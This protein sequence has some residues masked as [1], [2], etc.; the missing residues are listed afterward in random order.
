[1]FGTVF[2]HTISFVRETVWECSSPGMLDTVC[3]QLPNRIWFIDYFITTNKEH[4]SDW[5]HWY[6]GMIVTRPSLCKVS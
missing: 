5:L 1:M 4:K 2:L 3:G 6:F